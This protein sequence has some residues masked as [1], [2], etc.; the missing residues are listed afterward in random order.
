MSQLL[1]QLKLSDSTHEVVPW[2]FRIFVG[3]HIWDTNGQQQ[4][5]V[6]KIHGFVLFFGLVKKMETVG[7]QKT[8]VWCDANGKHESTLKPNWTAKQA[9]VISIDSS[10]LSPLFVF[11]ADLFK[12]REQVQVRRF[13]TI[14]D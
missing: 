14:V 11:Q 4:I 3:Q 9:A 2:C 8:E 10:L 13:A 6:R 5:L 7:Q 12:Y 1:D